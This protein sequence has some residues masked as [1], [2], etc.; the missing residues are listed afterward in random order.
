MTGEVE[1]VVA[2]ATA[3]T[4]NDVRDPKMEVITSEID[5]YPPFTRSLTLYHVVQ[6]GAEVHVSC[7]FCVWL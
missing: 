5:L 2:A 6:E 7:R 3:D 1:G 4:V